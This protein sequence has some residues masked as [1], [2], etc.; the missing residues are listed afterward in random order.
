MNKKRVISFLYTGVRKDDPTSAIL[1]EQG[2]AVKSIDMFE[3]PVVK[4]LI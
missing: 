3:D 4:L 2:E 1:I